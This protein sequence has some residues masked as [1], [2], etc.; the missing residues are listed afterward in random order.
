MMS[1]GLLA[2][3]VLGGTA[4]AHWDPA[5]SEVIHEKIAQNLGEDHQV[6]T[7]AFATV[8]ER[9]RN[10]AV[11]ERLAKLVEAGTV[12]QD[13]ADETQTWYDS[14]PLAALNVIPGRLKIDLE[15]VA[16]L[17]GVNGETFRGAVGDARREAVVVGRSERLDIAVAKG[18]ITEQKAAVM[19]EQFGSRSERKIGQTHRAEQGHEFPQRSSGGRNRGIEGS[20]RTPSQ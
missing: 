14:A 3:S 12:T 4:L 16:E 6:V 19:L 2:L 17:L 1:T 5:N 9:A 7:D 10:A 18:H 20:G 15:K 8:R 13:Q 11:A